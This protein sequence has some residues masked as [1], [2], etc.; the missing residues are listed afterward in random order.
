M[1]KNGELA[2][3]SGWVRASQA[4]QSRPDGH[5]A[6]KAGKGRETEKPSFYL[7]LGGN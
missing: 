1:S 5:E 3:E 2:E 4:A 6:E 7:T